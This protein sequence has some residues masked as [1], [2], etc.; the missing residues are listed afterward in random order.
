MSEGHRF[1]F[2]IAPVSVVIMIALTVFS[3]IFLPLKV[4]A[5]VLIGGALV[6]VNLVFFH[7]ILGP[8][9]RPRTWVTPKKVLP[10][11]YILFAITIA[12]VSLL[13][14]TH[15]VNPLGLLLGLS[16]FILTI[17]CVLIPE[18][19]AILFRKHAKEAT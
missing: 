15:A 13:I 18:V 6:C 11:Y 2:K 5:S 12:I 14:Y 19:G 1:L 9:L 17:F 8:A 4:A 3:V 10:G 7:R 16:T